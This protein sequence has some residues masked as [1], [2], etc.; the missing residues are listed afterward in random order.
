VTSVIA[1]G[2]WIDRFM[3]VFPSVWRQDTLPANLWIIAVGTAFLFLGALV[4]TVTRFL[5]RYPP[6]PLNDPWLAPHPDDVHVHPKAGHA[7]A[8]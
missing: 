4:F 5:S 3:Q 6:V 2:L 1:V 8:H 7:V